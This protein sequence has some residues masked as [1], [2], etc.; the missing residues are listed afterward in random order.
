MPVLWEEVVKERVKRLKETQNGGFGD[1]G[2]GK[3]VAFEGWGSK[4]MVS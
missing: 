1:D 4:V 3:E 2:S